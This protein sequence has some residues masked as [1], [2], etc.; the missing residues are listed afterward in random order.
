MHSR[1]CQEDRTRS[2][3]SGG[4]LRGRSMQLDKLTSDICS[5]D[6]ATHKAI[7][8]PTLHH[9]FNLSD[10]TLPWQR[11]ES[12]LSTYIDMIES[13][14]AVALHA[15]VGKSLEMDPYSGVRRSKYNTDPWALVPY[16]H[17]DLTNCLSTWQK[18]FSAIE[19]R[20]GISAEDEDDH[21][22]TP[23]CGRSALNA[24]SIPRGFAY[25][26]LSYAR[27]PGIW[28]VAPGVRLP[29]TNEFINQP[30]KSIAQQY[31]KETE[32]V[33]MP[34]LFFRC[35]GY[36]TSRQANF[37]WPYSTVEKVPCGLYLDAYPNKENP[38]QDACRLV[39]PFPLGANKCARTSDGHPIQR[40]HV[41]LYGHGINP[42]IMRHGPKLFAILE[43]WL[44][45]VE[46]GFWSVDAQG[47]SG[48]V[49]VW[50]QAD[51]EEHWAKYTVSGKS[52]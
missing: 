22:V 38:F 25:D 9:I 34:I 44:N 36:V 40:S 14:K 31:P 21:D 27:Q 10:P 37:R 46:S 4:E 23:L 12:I 52:V 42:R 13:G 19:Q 50:K 15:S 20:A 24:A 45:N 48:G 11:L 33:N 32:G 51:T 29:T 6:Q 39:L 7:F 35:E 18:L 5:Y 41:E 3:Y 30:F 8:M 28:F 2:K 17:G 26:L 49:E 47:V 16:T 43:S 1:L